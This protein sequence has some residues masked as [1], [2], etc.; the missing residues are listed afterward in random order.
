MAE[1]E[2]AVSPT[3][4]EAI[5]NRLLAPLSHEQ[6]RFIELMGQGF[7]H[8]S[9]KWPIFDFLEGSLDFEG[10]DA[11][12]VLESFPRLD[13]HG[14]SYAAVWFPRVPGRKP[15]PNES[16]ALTALGLHHL[17]QTRASISAGLVGRIV[18]VMKQLADIR[19]RR[20]PSPTEVRAPRVN[21]TDQL[22]EILTRGL[23]PRFS[24]EL[25]NHE[26]ATWGAGSSITGED[27]PWMHELPR[28][29]LSFQGVSTIEDYIAR[30][31][32]LLYRP[33]EPQPLEAPNPLDLVA[34]ID[35]LDT[36]WRVAIQPPRHLF[37]LRGAQGI[38]QLAF[39]A[40]NEDEFDSR[41]TVLA[42]ILRSSRDAV[43]T[44][45]SPRRGEPLRS[46]RKHLAS[47]VPAGEARLDRA[48][49]TLET[50]L[51]IRDGGQHR[52]AESRAAQ[53]MLTLGVGYPPPSWAAA[54]AVVSR[55]AIEAL[56]AIREELATIAP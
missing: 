13:G 21:S 22:A 40:A 34:A 45:G 30:T 38:A 27:G 50:V 33:P 8:D 19:F 20:K 37:A 39:A 43:P 52:E 32:E 6:A 54:W 46:V 7:S 42:E 9:G 31:V 14:G 10:L 49:D 26:P 24:W 23:P 48:I 11:W 29:L 3:P 44:L 18:A 55:R 16:I 41:L 2:D 47:L 17:E 12:T 51:A 53:A 5:A 1:H 15:G 56:D 35:F 36:V 28:Q 4:I 25:L